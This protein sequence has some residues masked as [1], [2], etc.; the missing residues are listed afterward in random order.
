MQTAT[1]R[2]I[3]PRGEVLGLRD[4]GYVRAKVRQSTLRETE[5]RKFFSFFGVFTILRETIFPKFQPNFSNFGHN[6]KNLRESIFDFRKFG[7]LSETQFFF[8]FFERLS[9]V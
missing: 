7:T 4:D 8:M 5:F 9:R 6:F 2:K 1:I 3:L